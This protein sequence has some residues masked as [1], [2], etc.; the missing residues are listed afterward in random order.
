MTG[1]PTRVRRSHDAAVD[2]LTPMWRGA[3]VFRVLTFAFVLGVQLTFSADYARPGLSWVLVGLIGVWTV[4]TV[5]AFSV[6]DGRRV[7]LAVADVAVVT[8]LMASTLLVQ[9][10]EQVADPTPTITTLWSAN[11]VVTAAVL[12]GARVGTAVGALV[13]AISLLVNGHI[14]TSLARDSVILLLLGAVLG[15]V[16]DTA[17]RSHAALA[18]ALRAE[19]ALVERE[20]LARAV[21]DSVLQVLAF[22]RREGAVLGGPGAEL[23][24]LAGDQEIALRALVATPAREGAHGEVDLRA[25]LQEQA[26]P[27]VSVSVPGTPVPLPAA[28]AEELAAVAGAALSNTAL[29]AGEQARAFVLLE[30]L[31]DEVVLSIR[32]DGVGIAPGRL[33]QAQAQ[34]RIGVAR[35]IRGRVRDLGGRAQV[36]SAPGAGTEW[37]VRLPR[38][39]AAAGPRSW[40]GDRG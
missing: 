35:S 17:R 25:L 26:N 24:R 23:A 12:A 1:P 8:A 16:A 22:V 15:V 5:W 32:D 13:A 21:H 14:T 27:V 39:R 31:G 37:E 38:T 29:H 40:R 20:H 7:W 4:V 34:G 30:D 33:A 19:A 6:A 18:Q 11:P 10:P 28:V 3:A 36:E 2:P 9:T